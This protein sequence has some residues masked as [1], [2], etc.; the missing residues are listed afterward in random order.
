MTAL[1]ALGV[2]RLSLG[3]ENFDPEILSINNRAHDAN[4]IDKAYDF[5]RGVG[6]EQIN[7]DLIAGMIGETDANWQECIEK[8]LAMKPDSITVY[9]MEVPFNTTIFKRMRDSGDAAAPVADWATKRRWV[10]EAFGAFEAAGYTIGS[11]YTAVARP[12]IEFLYRDALWSGADMLGIGVSSF[13][14]MGGIHYQN[15][16]QFDDYVA[17]VENGRLPLKRAMKPTDEERM[18]REFVLQMKLGH[19]ESSYFINRFD[20]DPRER[21]KDQIAARVKDGLFSVDNGTIRTTRR[22]LLM[23]DE[24]LHDFFLPH[25]RQV[26]RD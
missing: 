17:A 26:I 9:Q 1:A 11:A 6:F 8:T 22:G 3:V 19:V 4:A 12:E 10:D 20:V 23:I 2:T 25:H 13:S 18:I 15:E 5:A 14:H 16:S 24:L 21:F 7:I